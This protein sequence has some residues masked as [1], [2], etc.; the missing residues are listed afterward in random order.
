MRQ[1]AEKLQCEEEGDRVRKTL[2]CEE[3]GD[4]VRKTLQCEEEGDRV[5]KNVTGRSRITGC[6]LRPFRELH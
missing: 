2:Q 5:R 3:E 4:R 1:R 6:P